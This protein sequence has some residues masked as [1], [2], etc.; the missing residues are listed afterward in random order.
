MTLLGQNVIDLDRIAQDVA[1]GLIAVEN[2]AGVHEEV[3]GVD[4]T[5]FRAAGGQIESLLANAGVANRTAV[6]G[7]AD[8]WVCNEAGYLKKYVL[9][10]TF[11]DQDGQ[12]IRQT[13]DMLVTGEN[14]PVQVTIPPADK[15]VDMSSMMRGIATASAA[16][17]ATPV[18]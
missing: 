13:M 10:A 11:E 6:S 14:Q 3:D 18:P 8:L 1:G 4:T 9:Q 12:P 7:Q 16:G 15:V 17:T 5:H 2:V